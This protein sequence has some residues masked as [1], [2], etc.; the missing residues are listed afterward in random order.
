LRAFTPTSAEFGT[1]RRTKRLDWI[2]ISEELEFID[3]VV[4]PDIVSD[5]RALLA[6]I[7]WAKGH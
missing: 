5:H 1:Y 4:L 6:R 2:L 3:Y 7:G